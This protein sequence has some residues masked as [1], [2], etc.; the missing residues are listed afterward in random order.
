MY[1]PVVRSET[2]LTPAEYRVLTFLLAVGKQSV[3][4]VT[5]VVMED[6]RMLSVAAIARRLRMDKRNVT[7]TTEK[8]AK[9]VAFPGRK[10]WTLVIPP[11][12][13]AEYLNVDKRRALQLMAFGVPDGC[14]GC[15]MLAHSAKQRTVEEYARES[16]RVESDASACLSWLADKGYVSTRLTYKDGKPN[17]LV[18][19]VR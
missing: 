13:G 1:A 2:G 12:E 18:V 11:I 5:T 15:W 7:K 17:Q 9:R 3:D 4:L 10:S 16:G 6:S 19:T 14:L 8:V